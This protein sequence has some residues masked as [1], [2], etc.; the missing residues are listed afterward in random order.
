MAKSNND[1]RVTPKGAVTSSAKTRA[2]L[3][4]YLAKLAANPG[5]EG[6]QPI[7]A[8]NPAA[9]APTP[10]SPPVAPIRAVQGPQEFQKAKELQSKRLREI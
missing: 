6:D 1:F 9:Q 2:S 7:Q 10:S 8:L 5:T 4:A 3:A